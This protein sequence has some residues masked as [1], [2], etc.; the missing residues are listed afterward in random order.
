MSG[1]SVQGLNK[2]ERKL[3]ELRITQ[4][5]QPIGDVEEIMSMF[6]T[7]KNIIKYYRMSTK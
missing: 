1:I 5:K 2:K 3:L 4:C 6:H 7:P